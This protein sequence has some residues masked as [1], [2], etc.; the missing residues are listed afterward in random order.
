MRR[1]GTY[2]IISNKEV[3]KTKIREKTKD[4]KKDKALKKMRDIALD[5]Y[6]TPPGQYKVYYDDADADG[7]M[8]KDLYKQKED[9][10]KKNLE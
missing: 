4:E 8:S 2:Y 1:N 7:A 10:R 3:I 5:I 6:E 9:T